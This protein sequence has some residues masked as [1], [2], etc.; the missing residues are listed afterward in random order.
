MLL[1]LT[2]TTDARDQ[3]VSLRTFAREGEA[4]AWLAERDG[5]QAWPGSGNFHRR[6]ARVI[7]VPRYRMRTAEKAAYA[8]QRFSHCASRDQ[9]TACLALF[10]RAADLAVRN[11]GAEVCADYWADGAFAVIE[12]PSLAPGLAPQ[13]VVTGPAPWRLAVD[14]GDAVGWLTTPQRTGLVFLDR[15]DPALTISEENAVEQLRR[16]MA[17]ATDCWA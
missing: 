3:Q 17:D 7:D 9:A 14:R 5:V 6:L 13:V 15:E 12:Q 2:Q 8:S 16:L 1:G 4:R 10:E 11:I